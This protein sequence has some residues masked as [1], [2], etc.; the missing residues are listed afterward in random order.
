MSWQEVRDN[1]AEYE[2]L[3][4]SEL[5]KDLHIYSFDY[6]FD[7]DKSVRWNRD[8]A[9]RRNQEYSSACNAM[10]QS[11]REAKEHLFESA[12]AYIQQELDVSKEKA[13]RIFDFCNRERHS[14]GYEVVLDFVDEVIEVLA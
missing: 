5:P 14:S 4:K 11:I 3:L 8:E 7:M 6:I 2:R 13:G 12:I 10:V 9:A 1:L